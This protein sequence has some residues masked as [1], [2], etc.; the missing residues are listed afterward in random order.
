MALKFEVEKLEDVD[1]G[2]RP[3]YEESEGKF[4]LKVNGIPKPEVD[5][6]LA[7][8]IKALE[9]NNGKLLDEKRKAKEEAA[10]KSGDIDS[11][12]KSWA[13]KLK[14]REDELTG[15]LSQYEKLVSD[16]SSGTAARKLASEIFKSEFS[17]LVMPHITSRLT[18]EMK[19]GKAIVRVLDKAGQPS[20]LS[21][22]DLKKEFENDAKY[23][24]LVVG[25][26]AD[27][28]GDIG[29][30]GNIPA[31][32]MPRAQFD[33]LGPVEKAKFCTDGGTLLDK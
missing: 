2:L 24:P 16:L 27:G 6:T 33:A 15:S 1:E 14:A 10:R 25:S 9:T 23:A 30:P 11:I 3:L 31:K 4:R 21:V 18:T 7:D 32:T 20:A 12:E 13:E 5:N 19:D 8:R 26:R 17:E 28:G 29:K 22:D